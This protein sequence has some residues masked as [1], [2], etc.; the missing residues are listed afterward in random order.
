M[1]LISVSILP[2][3]HSLALAAVKAALKP[4]L[5]SGAVDRAT[6]K[7]AAEAASKVIPFLQLAACPS[8]QFH[9]QDGTYESPH[10]QQPSV[11]RAHCVVVSGTPSRDPINPACIKLLFSM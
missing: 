11:W 8:C 5:Q 4:R 1:L 2:Q 6:F 9:S 3:A 10:A 7:A